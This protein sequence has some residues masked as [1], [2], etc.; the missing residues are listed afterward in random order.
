MLQGEQ[1]NLRTEIAR[2]QQGDGVG[3]GY[4]YRSK[5]LIGMQIKEKL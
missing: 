2:A 5:A 3:D 1:L 4:V